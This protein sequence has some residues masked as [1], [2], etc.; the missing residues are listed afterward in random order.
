MFLLTRIDIEKYLEEN[1]IIARHDESNDDN[2][3]TR[4]KI[5]NIVIPYI[6]R[7]FNPNII[8]SLERLSFIAKEQENYI[9]KKIDEIYKNICISYNKSEIVLN[10]KEF[11]KLDKLLEKKIILYSI[12]K[13]FGNTKGIEKIHIEDIIKLCNNNVGNKYLTPN[14]YL[15]I[16]LKDKNLKILKIK[17]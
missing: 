4:N 14:K 17:T 10:L 8:N 12:H 15:K 9:D 11:N 5:R 3:Y 1:H 16:L 13:L 7:E 2:I 6:Q